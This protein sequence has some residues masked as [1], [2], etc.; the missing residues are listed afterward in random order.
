MFLHWKQLP[1]WVKGGIV[2]VGIFIT[3]PVVLVWSNSRISIPS[4]LEYAPSKIESA[5][6]SLPY[7]ENKNGE[8]FR[9][10]NFGLNVFFISVL[11]EFM[12][13]FVGLGSF[14]GYL[15]GKIKKH[16][17]KFWLTPSQE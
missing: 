8:W 10:W 2:A 7:C 14:V 17:Q 15:Y 6:L 4:W 16:M 11:L 12:V 13:L 3:V 9:C 1:Y 5:A